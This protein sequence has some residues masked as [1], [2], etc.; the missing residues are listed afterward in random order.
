MLFTRAL[1]AVPWVL[2]AGAWGF[3][4][5][6][7][8]GISPIICAAGCGGLVAVLIGRDIWRGRHLWNSYA[9]RFAALGEDIHDHL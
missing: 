9:E 1:R 2:L 6:L 8:F 7:V 3:V 4:C 5:G